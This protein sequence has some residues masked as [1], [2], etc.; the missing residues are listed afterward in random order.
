MGVAREVATVVTRLPASEPDGAFSHAQLSGR[1]TI[2]WTRAVAIGPL[3]GAGGQTGATINDV[4]L[5]T[6]AGAL[7][8][9]LLA[10]GA[11]VPRATALI[12]V[13]LRSMNDG[14]NVERG[15]E[16]GLAHVRLPVGE[17]NAAHRLR[18]V[19]CEMNRVKQHGEAAFV[20]G[21]LAA[22]GCSPAGL[23]RHLADLYASCA[24]MVITNVA[25]PREAVSLGGVLMVGFTLWVPCVGPLRLGLSVCSYAG[26]LAF[27]VYADE[28]LDWAHQLEELLEHELAQVVIGTA[29]A[30][31][32]TQP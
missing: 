8:Q 21:A 6:I 15:N 3:K 2:G 7:R 25:G 13:N 32:S 30:A 12:P 1:K 22:L 20:Y 26:Q 23:G 16:V 19:K 18:A 10:A 29:T 31:P 14:L 27:G 4:A 28:T 9:H 17:D 24:S 5:A 11:D